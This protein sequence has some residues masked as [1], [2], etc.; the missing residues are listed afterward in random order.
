MTVSCLFPSSCVF[1]ITHSNIIKV[2]YIKD[3]NKTRITIFVFT[4]VERF[5]NG[6]PYAVSH[7][8]MQETPH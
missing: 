7:E 1:N 2:L 3:F 5:P 4:S 8:Q 6:T